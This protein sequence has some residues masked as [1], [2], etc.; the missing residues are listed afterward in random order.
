MPNV[1]IVYASTDGHTEKICRH[2][3][4]RLQASGHDVTLASIGEAPGPNGYQG[5]LLGAAIR[6]G[7]HQPAVRTYLSDH[8]AT[9]QAM[10]CGLFSVNLSAR[11]PNRATVADNPYLR[12]LLR[13]LGW[14]PALLA[15]LAGKLDYPRY[16]WADRQMI[17]LIMWLT[18]GPTD[19]QCVHDFT[20]W[21]AVEALAANFAQAVAG[22][23]K[24]TVCQR[25]T[26]PSP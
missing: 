2:I 17:R 16:R 26:V 22:T 7:R 6:Y 23:K 1:L 9:L 14:Q 3:G 5:L 18:G 21:Q 20:D 12:R 15:V 11:K 4:L 24:S 25:S 10:P 19:P 8:A 13:Q